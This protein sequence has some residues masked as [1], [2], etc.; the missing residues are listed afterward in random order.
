MSSN[1]MNVQGWVWFPLRHL[2]MKQNL[3]QKIQ[4]LIQIWTSKKT[5]YTISIV[6]LNRSLYFVLIFESKE[7]SERIL[8]LLSIF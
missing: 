2:E 3:D 1:P 8:F 4:N 6:F 5:P 7:V